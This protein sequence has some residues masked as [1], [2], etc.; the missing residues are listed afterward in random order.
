MLSGWSSSGSGAMFAITTVKT[1]RKRQKSEAAAQGQES[2]LKY[3]K[4]WNLQFLVCS[5]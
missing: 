4:K 5:K 3:R 2:V 1:P